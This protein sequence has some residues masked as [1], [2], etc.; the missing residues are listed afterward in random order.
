MPVFVP[1]PKIDRW[2]VKSKMQKH[3]VRQVRAGRTAL[4][5]LVSIAFSFDKLAPAQS[6]SAA[7]E[8]QGQQTEKPRFEFRKH[9][10][11][12][13]INSSFPH[14]RTNKPVH[15]H[16]WCEHKDGIVS[17]D[18][19]EAKV[20]TSSYFSKTVL[21]GVEVPPIKYKFLDGRLFSLDVGM[22]PKDY[23][24]IREMLIGKYGKPSREGMFLGTIHQTEWEFKGEEGTLQLNQVNDGTSWFTFRNPEAEAVLDSRARKKY[25]QRGKSAL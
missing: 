11:G 20:K 19:E 4:L 7:P 5:I 23:W 10:I 25:Q 2:I 8:T 14:W 18:D 1:L 24:K 17:C 16:P 12:E 15:P 13:D 6:D 21:G 9:T 22:F 3:C